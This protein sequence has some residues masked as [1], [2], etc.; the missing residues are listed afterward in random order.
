MGIKL[1][2]KH[3]GNVAT[4]PSGSLQLKNI[5]MHKEELI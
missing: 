2:E 3:F 4:D 1:C 5:L